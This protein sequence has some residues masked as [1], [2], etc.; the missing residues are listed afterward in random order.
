MFLIDEIFIVIIGLCFGSFITMASYRFA[1]EEMPTREFIVKNSFCPHCKNRL[2]IRHLFPVFSWLFSRGKCGFCQEKISIR[3][4]LIEIFSAALFLGIY[5][6]LGSKIDLKLVLI[7]L[8]A[9]TLIIMSVVDLESYFIPDFTQIFLGFLIVIYHLTIPENYKFDYY[10]YSGMLLLAI[11]LA[12]HFGFFL[13]TKKQGIGEDDIKFLFFA[14]FMLGAHQILIFM[15]LSGV[16]GVIF[17]PVWKF[18]KKDD[19]F[20]FAPALSFAFLACITFKIDYIE[21]F[22]LL[23]YWFQK[24][25]L[26]TAY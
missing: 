20:P 26:Q 6:A 12:L 17:G 14:G 18:L 13:I 7:L 8:M 15:I 25:I 21:F 19:T 1:D 23:L 10:Y 3:Y 11:G 2:K 16:F 5:L 9:V 22:G 24:Y 4:P